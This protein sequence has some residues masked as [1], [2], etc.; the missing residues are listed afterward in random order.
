MDEGFLPSIASFVKKIKKWGFQQVYAPKNCSFRGAF[1]GGSP[2][3]K[4]VYCLGSWFLF[5]V[6]YVIY[7]Q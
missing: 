3:T 2:G 6:L 5:G 1:R 7:I 4:R